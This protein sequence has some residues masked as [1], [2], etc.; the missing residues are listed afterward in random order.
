MNYID[1]TTI[2]N[3]IWRHLSDFITIFVILIYGAFR[4]RQRETEHKRTIIQLR[5]G[6]ELPPQESKP[7]TY[8]LVATGIIS[9]ILLTCSVGAIMLRPKL[10]YGGE[11]LFFI[12]L[13]FVSVFIMLVLMLIRDI[14]SRRQHQ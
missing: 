8:K 9:F 2:L 1:I 6:V 13:V 3:F 5:E 11:T 12:A 14:K 7:E 10:R 4:Y